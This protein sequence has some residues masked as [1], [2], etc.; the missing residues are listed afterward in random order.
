[1]SSPEYGPA[2]TLPPPGTFADVDAQRAM[3]TPAGAAATA[4]D[5]GPKHW[6]WSNLTDILEQ[7]VWQV[8]SIAL[9]GSFLINLF[10]WA[11]G[12]ATG[13][14][15]GVRGLGLGISI[16]FAMWMSMA[17]LNAWMSARLDWLGAP[18][19]AFGIAVLANLVVATGVLAAVYFMFFVVIGGEAPLAWLR[20]QRF[21]MYF[22]SILIGLLITAI[23]QGAWF[24]KLWKESVVQAE[25]LKAAGLSAKYEALNAQINPHFLFNS[26]NVL[27][28]LVRT[29]P[30]AAEDFIRGLGDVY[31]Y[32]L[33]VRRA[34]LVPLSRE[35]D[36][37]RAYGELLSRRFGERLELSLPSAEDPTRAGG[38]AQVVP[39]ALQMLV[40][41]AVKHNGA[42]RRE[43][44]RVR[45]EVDEAR[46]SIC[47]R[48]NRVALFEP[49][50][51][52]GTGLANIRERY[53]LATGREI[54]VHDG[55]DEFRVC[56]PLARP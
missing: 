14:V 28:A 3:D 26:L 22:G 2:A 24:V 55:E 12:W 37:L 35:L 47:V 51:S 9:A 4:E 54:A 30:D 52:K 29:D 16:A 15:G 38:E 10:F 48:N 27:S 49:P 56:L 41:N 36:A 13:S 44:L 39:L 40:E 23:Y 20:R 19:R 8:A 33:D 11:I 5:A 6:L 17:Y 18:R 50:V 45:V 21:G 43:P 46:G 31:R 32:V 1:M 34:E 42:T 53:R 25:E 7:P